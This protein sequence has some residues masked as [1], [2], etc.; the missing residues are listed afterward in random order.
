MTGIKDN[1]GFLA[2]GSGV[3]QFQ[4]SLRGWFVRGARSSLASDAYPL[5][6]SWSG[7]AA[8]RYPQPSTRL[9]QTGAARPGARL[10]PTLLTNWALK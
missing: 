10:E 8:L 3:Q 9:P 5:S 6:G 7:R 4:L 2:T 1:V